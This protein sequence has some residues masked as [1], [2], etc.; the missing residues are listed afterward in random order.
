MPRFHN[1]IK[2]DRLNEIK[3]INVS[4]LSWKTY[5]R[6][7]NITFIVSMN[8]SPQI[9]LFFLQSFFISVSNFHS[10]I[11]VEIVVIRPEAAFSP[12][13]VW[14]LGHVANVADEPS[15]PVQL[16]GLF[17]YVVLGPQALWVAAETF[18]M[19]VCAT[20][21]PT[22]Y[23]CAILQGAVITVCCCSE[24]LGVQNP[25][26]DAATLFLDTWY[27]GTLFVGDPPPRVSVLL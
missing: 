19:P 17:S 21:G 16:F 7:L 11:A 25:C 13:G 15:G 2:T 5:Y 3:T 26:T 6:R 8:L 18:P 23:V 20:V 1:A 24:V 9:L 4:L 27:P 10:A 22:M 12:L 14:V